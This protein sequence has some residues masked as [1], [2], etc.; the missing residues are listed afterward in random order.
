MQLGILDGH[1]DLAGH[2]GQEVEIVLLEPAPA[3]TRVKL[4]DAQRS[5]LLVH[6]G[7]AEERANHAVADAVTVGKFGQN[8]LAEDRLAVAQ[9]ALKNRFADPQVARGAAPGPDRLRSQ[10]PSLAILEQDKPAFG[11]GKDLE[12]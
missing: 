4:D 12:E 8:I 10:D 1:A 5:L 9:H 7:G 6:D 2:R 11:A 3:I